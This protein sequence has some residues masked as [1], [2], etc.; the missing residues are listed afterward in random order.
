MKPQNKPATQPA[1]K[2]Q[3]AAKTKKTP[4]QARRASP[5]GMRRLNVGLSWEVHGK[6]IREQGPLNFDA[7]TCGI[8]ETCVEC[9]TLLPDLTTPTD[10]DLRSTKEVHVLHLD[11]PVRL[12]A[13]IAPLARDCGL[14]LNQGV[15]LALAWDA[16]HDMPTE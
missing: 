7:H 14:T 8:L 2:A 6:L 10:A 12:L 9:K 1:T 16:Q 15:A 13:E 5:P 3:P 11:L 4:S